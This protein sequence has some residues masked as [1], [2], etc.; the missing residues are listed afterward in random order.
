MNNTLERTKVITIKAS[1][2]RT[3]AK[4]YLVNV[5]SAQ[6][7]VDD[8]FA[9]ATLADAKLWVEKNYDTPMPCHW[10]QTKVDGEITGHTLEW[11]EEIL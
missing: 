9:S 6:G 11:K 2:F 3:W 10:K 8:Y 4:A 1:I 5:Y 7:E